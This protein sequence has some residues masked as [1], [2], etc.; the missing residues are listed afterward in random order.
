MAQTAWINVMVAPSGGKHS[1]ATSSGDQNSSDICISYDPVKVPV[2]TPLAP[3]MEIIR[4]GFQSRGF[5]P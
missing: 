2:T 5:K 4:T 1:L 3:L